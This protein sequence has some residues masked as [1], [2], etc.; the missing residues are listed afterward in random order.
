[1]CEGIEDGL[2]IAVAMPEAR[3]LVAV[4]VANMAHVALPDA[5][6]EIVLCAD[7]D[8]ANSKAA[9]ALDRAVSAHLG[10][11]RQVRVA[12]PPS[13]AKDFNQ[14]MTEVGW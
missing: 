1:M 8:P 7:N 3:V 6:T 2:S 14:M 12:R 5:I 9:L 13:G 10:A 4:S 11:G